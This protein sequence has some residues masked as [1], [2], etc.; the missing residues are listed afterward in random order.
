MSHLKK[1]DHLE[2]EF[3]YF[4]TLYCLSYIIQCL[5]NGK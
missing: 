3:N 5:V 2:A 4:D 1:S